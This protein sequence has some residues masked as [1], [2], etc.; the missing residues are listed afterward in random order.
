M[1]SGLTLLQVPSIARDFENFPKHNVIDVCS[2]PSVSFLRQIDYRLV[3][4]GENGRLF[5]KK[6]HIAYILN[7]TDI[8][9]AIKHNFKRLKFM[10]D[11]EY[12]D[13]TEYCKY[14]ST[15]VILQY[16]GQNILLLDDI[17]K[18]FKSM[19]KSVFLNMNLMEEIVCV[20]TPFGNEHFI[21]SINFGHVAN[22]LGKDNCLALLNVTSAFGC[23][24]GGVYDKFM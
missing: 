16:E 20:S 15:F 6:A 23:E 12:K 7:S 10:V 2:N 22:L 3:I 17:K 11:G 9:S 13:V 18:Y 24:G 21:N 14:F 4:Q 19:I 5:E 8:E 1:T